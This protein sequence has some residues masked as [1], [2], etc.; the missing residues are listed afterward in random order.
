MSSWDSDTDSTIISNS[1]GSQNVETDQGDFEETIGDKISN[2][3][4]FGGIVEPC[5]FKP[6]ASD[7]DE[8]GDGGMD[9]DD[10]NTGHMFIFLFMNRKKNR[11]QNRSHS[12]YYSGRNMA[13]TRH[14]HCGQ[15]GRRMLCPT[16]VG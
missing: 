2:G 15:N 11:E 10:E 5:R 6:C 1:E 8:D 7:S 12:L 3:N 4:A 13:R 14:G 9:S 16:V